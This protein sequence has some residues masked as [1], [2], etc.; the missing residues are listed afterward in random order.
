MAVLCIV[1]EDGAVME[2]ER[3]WIGLFDSLKR[4]LL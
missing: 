3:I 4:E 2:K 1:G